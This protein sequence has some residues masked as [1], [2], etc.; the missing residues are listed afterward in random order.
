MGPQLAP[1]EVE[2]HPVATQRVA[3]EGETA[4]AVEIVLGHGQPASFFFS[5]SFSCAGLALPPV[6]FITWPTKKPRSLSLPAR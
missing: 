5:S 6:A 4:D 3:L 1:R 2:R